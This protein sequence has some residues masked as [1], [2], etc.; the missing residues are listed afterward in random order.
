[1]PSAYPQGWLWRPK[2]SRSQ[3]NWAAQRWWESGAILINVDI[4]PSTTGWQ[5][6]LEADPFWTAIDGLVGC[7][8]SC[9]TSFFRLSFAS[10][11]TLTRWETRDMVLGTGMD[12]SKMWEMQHQMD[13]FKQGSTQLQVAQGSSW[14][15]KV[16]KY[17]NTLQAQTV[18]GG[19]QWKG[20]L[21]VVKELQQ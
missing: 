1:M 4:R 21:Y 7:H 16:E 6:S 2:S 13:H 14:C 11:A 5:L 3:P 17:N 20:T 9:F 15:V 8:L 18:A 10:C 12:G 19:S